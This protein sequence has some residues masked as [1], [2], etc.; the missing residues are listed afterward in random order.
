VAVAVSVA[1]SVAAGG[2]L[3]RTP[4]ATCQKA[5]RRVPKNVIV[6]ISDGWGYHHIEV[7]D[8]FQYGCSG[9]Q[10]YQRFPVQAGMSTFPHG[11]SY[12]PATVWSSFDAPWA[13]ATDS[14]AAATAMSTGVKTSEGA[15]GV[16]PAGLRLV[17][18][19]ELAERAGRAT[20]VVTSVPFSH[21]TPAGFVAHNA[22]RSDSVGIANEMIYHSGTD[23]I[24]GGGHPCFDAEG[25][26]N[27]CTGNTGYI[28]GDETWADLTDS[29]GAT[30]ADANGDGTRDRWTLVQSRAEFQ[31]LARG[32]TPRRVLGVTPVERTLQQ[33]RR[34]QATEPNPLTWVTACV[35]APYA[36]PRNA[37]VPTLAELSRAALNV[38]DGDRDG[39]ALMIEGGAVDWAAHDNSLGRL[40]EEQIDFNLA[41][42]A[43][44]SWITRNGGWQETLLVVTG[45]HECGYLTGPGSDPAWT[46]IVAQGRGVLP[47]AEFHSSD[48]TNLLVPLFARGNGAGR[49][50]GAA[51]ARDP[52]RGR[53][54]DNTELAAVLQTLLR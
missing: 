13:G 11:G 35:D 41:V 51:D 1:V 20:G 36:V 25:V 39:F 9:C 33:G 30:G 31:A 53:Y 46:P 2:V 38:L 19:F 4:G 18:A 34:C 27:G 28:G 50:A 43:V 22:T 17:H 45:D 37:S 44:T 15:I 29:D 32:P 49:L 16:D 26:G 40:I 7:T 48:H 12:D 47:H 5:A 52:R 42:D 10:T 54:L 6:M 3:A 8:A 24:I 14:A 23:V 21:A